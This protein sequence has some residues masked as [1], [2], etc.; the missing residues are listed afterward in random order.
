[1]FSF[2][3]QPQTLSIFMEQPVPYHFLSSLR[4]K[5]AFAPMVKRY[6]VARAVNFI[7]VSLVFVFLNLWFLWFG[8][9][10]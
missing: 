9:V 10:W 6:M 1:M 3:V 4:V 7:V 5:P 8:L 2:L